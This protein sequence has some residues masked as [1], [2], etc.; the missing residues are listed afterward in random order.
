MKYIN[1]MKNKIQIFVLFLLF[2]S[3]IFDPTGDFYKLKYIS[4]ILSFVLFGTKLL[5]NYKTSYFSSYQLIYLFAFC[6]FIPIYGLCITLLH[7][8]LSSLT[9][10][11]YIGFAI[12][13]LLASPVMTMNKEKFLQIFLYSLRVLEFVILLILI[14][15]VFDNDSYGITQFF[16][17]H[18]SMFMGFR[19][20]S[21]IPTYYI[22]FTASPLLI[23]LVAYDSSKLVNKYSLKNLLVFI[24]SIIAIFLTGTRFNMLVAILILPITYLLKTYTVRHIF[25]GLISFIILALFVTYNSFTSSFFISSESSN[26]VKIGYFEAYWPIFSKPNFFLLGQ[27]FNAHDWS[28]DFKNLLM[29]ADNDGTKTELTYLE[30]LR[31]FGVFFGTVLNFMTLSIPVIV[32]RYYHKFNFLVIGILIYLLSAALNPYLFST[33]G[34][35]LVLLFLISINGDYNNDN[36]IIKYKL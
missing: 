34:V 29:K 15:F 24:S 8:N 32:F 5:I 16:I 18:K 13:L 9:D 19:E 3:F 1:T 11:S 2:I 17:D 12:T 36:S 25:I 7:T 33:N 27:G 6:F 28:M 31:V 21:G 14:S 10:T 23:I 35:L 30:Y 20:Y 4:V 22:Y 26:N